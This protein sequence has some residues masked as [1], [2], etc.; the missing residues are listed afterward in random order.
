M[1]DRC[2]REVY[3]PSPL[4]SRPDRA[5][6]AVSAANDDASNRRSLPDHDGQTHRPAKLPAMAIA[7]SHFTVTVL[8]FTLTEIA[9]V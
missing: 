7:E 6:S 5:A 8:K 4:E 3:D 1:V 9:V 2:Q